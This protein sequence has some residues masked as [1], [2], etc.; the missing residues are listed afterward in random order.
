MASAPTGSGKTAAFVLPILLSLQ[1]PSKHGNTITNRV[2]L[3]AYCIAGGPKEELYY[4]YSF[5]IVYTQGIYI[6]WR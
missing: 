1:R 6:V 2:R 4:I 5:R 3:I